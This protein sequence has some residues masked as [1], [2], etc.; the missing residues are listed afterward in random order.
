[1]RLCWKLVPLQAV[2]SGCCFEPSAPT[3]L[4]PPPPTF[5]GPGSG[6]RLPSLERPS[7]T[8]LAPGFSDPWILRG[9]AG[10][11]RDASAFG[12]SCQGRIALVPSAVVDLRGDFPNLRFLAHGESDLT[13]VVR[14]SSG[15]TRCNDDSDG[16][17]PIVQGAFEAG[18]VE[19]YVGTF[20][21]GPT[22]PYTLGIT[23]NAALTP[24][25]LLIG[26]PSI[27]A[28][29]TT[30]RAGTLTVRS[31]RGGPVSVGDR[32]TYSEVRVPP[33]ANGHDVRWTLTCGVSVLY[34]AGE[35]GYGRA[36]DATWPTGTL[37]YDAETTSTDADP[38][39][40]WT[41]NS[42]RLWDDAGGPF[43]EFEIVFDAG[44]G[45]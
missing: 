2:L 27:V 7:A 12:P 45:T 6:P 20:E 26:Q 1:M 35:T 41:S 13:L 44:A 28:G 16:L 19:I 5:S 23:T 36:M 14:T 8:P 25:T 4:V 29:R 30:L 40:E 15:E 18:V 32:C 22:V 24:S 43:G 37:A 11:P 38:G 34:G 10:G 39:F 33:T 17:D 9:Q 3:P 42:I 31:A 21:V